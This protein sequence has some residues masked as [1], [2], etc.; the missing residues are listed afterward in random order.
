VKTLCIL[1]ALLATL[2][3]TPVGTLQKGGVDLHG[4][5]DVVAGWLKPYAGEENLISPVTVFAESADRVF[6]GSLGVTPKA[7]APPTL[8]VFNPKVPGAKVDHPLVIVNRNGEVIDRWAAWYDRF[9]SIHT[10]TIDPYDPEKHVWV[11]DR[12]SQQVMKFTHDGKTLV[13]ALGERGVAGTDEKHF[14]RPS[15]IAFLPDGSFYVSDGYDNRRIVKFDKSGKFLLQ[16]GKQGSAPGEFGLPH[17][18]SLDAEG[19]V[20]VADR[21]NDRIQVFDRNGKF[22]DQWPDFHNPSRVF[23]TQDQFAWVSDA[24]SN[25]FAKFDLKGKLITTFGTGG[26]FAGGMAAPHDFGVDPDGNL[27]VANPWN[28]T[29]DKYMPRKGADPSR[30]VGQRYK[31]KS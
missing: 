15:G 31:A 29:V 19:R 20:Y 28:F 5:Y 24:A 17:S 16:W 30:L 10:V 6:I 7:T 11:I 12:A 26:R 25:K 3:V 21:M 23:I 4:S 9:G 13:M 8:T 27:Y 2:L 14:G 1:A 22:L 18:V